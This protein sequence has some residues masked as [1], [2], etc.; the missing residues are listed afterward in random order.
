M[1]H[2][3]SYLHLLLVLLSAA[4]FQLGQRAD[5]RL[6]IILTLTVGAFQFFVCLLDPM[7]ASCE[8]LF[9]YVFGDSQS[10]LETALSVFFWNNERNLEIT[11]SV[12][13]LDNE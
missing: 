2:A 5:R 12:F 6:I 11:P 13:F 10:N 3:L 1:S 9:L 8:N 4:R 7:P